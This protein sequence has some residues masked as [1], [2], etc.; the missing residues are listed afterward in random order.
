MQA[1]DTSH[2]SGSKSLCF[3]VP[4]FKRHRLLLRTIVLSPLRT[5]ILHTRCSMSASGKLIGRKGHKC[6]L[7][8][9]HRDIGCN[10]PQCVVNRML[11][12]R[13][14]VRHFHTNATIKQILFPYSL[15][16]KV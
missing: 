13:Y 2:E 16:M 1:K 6:R 7:P 9:D 11:F 10:M 5:V 12:W 15:E 3:T 14:H 8:G 4:Q